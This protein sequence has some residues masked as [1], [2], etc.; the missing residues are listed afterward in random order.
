[1]PLSHEFQHD[2]EWF[3]AY[4]PQSNEVY[5]MDEDGRK[6]IHM[7]VETCTE[8]AGT[9]CQSEEYHT[10]FSSSVLDEQHPICHLEASAVR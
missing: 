1:M 6:P 8:G 10:Q 7:F 2:I 4:L 5:I 9:L 3:K